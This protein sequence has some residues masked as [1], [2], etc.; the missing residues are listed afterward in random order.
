MEGQL[1]NILVK[2]YIL[3]DSREKNPRIDQV[4]QFKTSELFYDYL[5]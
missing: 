5:T 2:S 3:E 1:H 4:P